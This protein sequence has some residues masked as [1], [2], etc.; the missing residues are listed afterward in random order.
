MLLR[1]NREGEPHGCS[2]EQ[3]GRAET[4][5]PH[6]ST[7]DKIRKIRI[8]NITTQTRD[9]RSETQIGKASV[10]PHRTSIIGPSPD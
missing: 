9:S 4:T 5:H 2:E 7:R 8:D 6:T 1:P 3:P 10:N